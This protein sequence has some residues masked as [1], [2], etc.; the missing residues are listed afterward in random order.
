[1]AAENQRQAQD[2]RSGLHRSHPK[3]RYG[4]VNGPFTD[5]PTAML[6]MWP[7]Q[8]RKLKLPMADPLFCTSLKMNTLASVAD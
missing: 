3:V 6:A 7:A 4:P 8:S 2:D 1:L 5:F